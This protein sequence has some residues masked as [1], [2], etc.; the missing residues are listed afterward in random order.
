MQTSPESSADHF[1]PFTPEPSIDILYS[2]YDLATGLYEEAWGQA[3]HFCRFTP[4]E[5]FLQ[6]IAR[7]EHYLATK[8]N[9]QRG[10]RVLDVG[11]GVGGPAREIA[12]FAD[13]HVTGV[14]INDY[15]IQRAR[16]AA[17]TAGMAD[18]LEF[19]KGDFMVCEGL[20]RHLAPEW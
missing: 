10:M 11:C 7:H 4:S 13:I 3:F 2:Y 15:Q 5:P 12:R 17:T 9:L 6:A 18:Q 1:L 20:K 19:V 8:M 14:N 16:L